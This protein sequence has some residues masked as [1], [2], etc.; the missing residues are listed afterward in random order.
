MSEPVH[1]LYCG[2]CTL[3]VE[4]CEFGKTLKKCKQWL[5]ENNSEQYNKLYNS[6]A[7]AQSSLSK[8]R[9]A[10]ISESLAKMQ[11]KEERKQA[12]EMRKL[13]QEKILIKRIPRTKHKNIIA[14][15][16][17]DQFDIDMKKLAKKFSSK[18]ATGASVSKNIEKKEEIIIQGDVGEE[19]EEYL[20]EML[21]EKG[22]EGVKVGIIDEKRHLRKKK[23]ATGI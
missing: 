11:L 2:E 12:R 17:L 10:E 14:I 23:E 9:E 4:Y 3:P 7:P 18:F 1:V 15:S 22:L 21:K 5:H 6:E 8:E 16:N 19:V 20:I 13:Q